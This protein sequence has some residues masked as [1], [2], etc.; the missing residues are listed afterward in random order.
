MPLG[1]S[2]ILFAVMRLA[3]GEPKVVLV[4][5]ES[6]RLAEERRTRQSSGPL[7]RLRSPRPL[8]ASVRHTTGGQ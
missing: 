7:A 3:S 4:G 6:L 5:A 2:M 1:F 8:T